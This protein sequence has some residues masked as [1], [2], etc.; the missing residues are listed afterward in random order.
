MIRHAGRNCVIF[1]R[2]MM[3]AFRNIPLAR[4]I[5]WLFGF[6]WDGDFYVE[7]VLPFGLATAP[8]IFNLFAEALQWIIQ[9]H[10]H[11]ELVEHFLD[12]IIYVIAEIDASESD[13]RRTIDEY[14]LITDILGVPRQDKK[15]VC[16]TIESILGYEF[17]THSFIMR[18][19]E[20][21]LTRAIEA[22]RHAVRQESLTLLEAQS[23]T[24]FL[25]FCAPA[26]Q[27]GWVF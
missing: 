7:T 20:D 24:G 13:I 15:D 18:L 8:F 14:N 2:D 1:K 22:T 19:P 3:D 16:G 5:R 11:W 23:I 4:K 12:D 9:S 10:L 6:Q 17:D 27:L 25:A 26:V 21:K